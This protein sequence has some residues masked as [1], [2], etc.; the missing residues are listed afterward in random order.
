MFEKSK[1]ERFISY[2]YPR[3]RI[4]EI[5]MRTHKK[6]VPRFVNILYKLAYKTICVHKAK[7]LN[8]MHSFRSI[9]QSYI[10]FKLL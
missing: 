3:G 8:E 7:A 6:D 1:I 10:C 4:Y 9:Q 5:G 2:Q